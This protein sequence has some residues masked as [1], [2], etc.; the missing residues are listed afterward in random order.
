MRE[1]RALRCRGAIAGRPAADAAGPFRVYVG[2]RSLCCRAAEFRREFCDFGLA[3][4]CDRA[5]VDEVLLLRLLVVVIR[6]IGF[7]VRLNPLVVS[8]LHFFHGRSGDNPN[9]I[10]Q[11]KAGGQHF[12]LVLPEHV[13]APRIGYQAEQTG[14]RCY[15]ENDSLF[16]EGLYI[17]LRVPPIM[18]LIGSARR[19][20]REWIEAARV[21]IRTKRGPFECSRSM[22]R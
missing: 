20:C 22:M 7:S 1:P 11:R 3:H 16:V 10:C 15:G 14:R 12:A 4:L 2:R 18:S 19:R 9:K 21:G 5:F 13:E 6:L 17:H 8:L